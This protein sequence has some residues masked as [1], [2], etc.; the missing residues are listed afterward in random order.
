MQA[1]P[2][3][4]RLSIDYFE[5]VNG[6]I[7]SQIA[8]KTEFSHAENVRSI[9]IGSF[10][11]RAGSTLLGTA[12]TATANNGL[13][14]FRS[15][16]ADNSFLYRISTVSGSTN[17]YY[18]KTSTGVWTALTGEGANITAGDFDNVV[19]EGKMF[20]VNYNDANR[21]IDSDGTTVVDSSS[22]AGHLYNSPNANNI[23]FYKNTLYVADYIQGAVRYPTTILKSSY[24]LGIIALVS[25]DPVTPYTTLGIT[26]FK[27]F[28]T[29]AGGNTAD[30]YRGNSKVAVF[31]ITSIASDSI[32]G[33]IVFE[34]GFTSVLSADEIWVAGTYAGAKQFR[35]A[36]N[37]TTQ[38]S[39]IKQ[40]DTMKLSGGDGS[41]IKMMEVI[42]NVMMIA[43]N[44]TLAIW[45]DYVLQSFDLNIG[46]V[47]R[48]GYIKNLGGLYF[49]HYTGVFVS[50]GEMP[51]LISAK[52]E[53]YIQGATTVNKEAAVAG[54]KGRSVFWWIGDSTLTNPDGSADKTLSNV[55]LEYNITQEDW[56]VHTNIKATQFETFVDTSDSDRLIMLTT[57]TNYPSVEFLSGETD[58]GSEIMMQAE[59]NSFPLAGYFEKFSYVHEVLLDVERGTGIQVFVSL[60]RGPFYELEGVASK[61]ASIIKVTAADGDRSKPP[62]CREITLSLRHSLKQLCRVARVAINFIP[63]AEEEPQHEQN[64][65]S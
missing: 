31:T 8:K 3:C 25:G 7:A 6:L 61:G 63:T 39:S 60:D 11:K 47:S 18:L 14:F 36:V 23:C 46:C 12:I 20:L 37:A 2:N 62:R 4:K 49:L 45:N 26:E 15:T 34:V 30:I 55:V 41:S 57:N 40:Y 64:D 59:T 13:F 29:A 17:I 48:K 35:W 9:N 32:T 58:L 22:A 50:N 28:T 52:V 54:K 24:P 33:T 44:N 38:G 53:R 1:N 10:E 43:N 65:G 51:K 21:Y 19:A 5:G 27:Y 56:F 42:G 16:A